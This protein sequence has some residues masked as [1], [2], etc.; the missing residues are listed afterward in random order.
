MESSKVFG[1]RLE[2][3]KVEKLRQLARELSVVQQRDIVWVDLVRE[4]IDH[5]IGKNEQGS[6]GRVLA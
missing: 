5:V 6:K 2:P 3:A 1:I 4:G